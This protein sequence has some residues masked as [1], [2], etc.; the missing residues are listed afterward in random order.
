MARIQAGINQLLTTAGVFANLSPTLR[1]KAET[2]A[3]TQ[4]AE[5]KAAIQ[6]EAFDTAFSEGVQIRE[7]IEGL[8]EKLETDTN[9]I[10]KMMAQSNLRKAKEERQTNY[11]VTADVTEQR[12]ATAQEL[13]DL[14]PTKESYANLA[15]AKRDA[16]L[17]SAAAEGNR[18]IDREEAMRKMQKKGMDKVKQKYSFQDL[19][20]DV[21]KA[22]QEGY[23]NG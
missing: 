13:F 2:R 12:A 7:K 19:I 14:K 17:Y 5:R 1:A 16:K 22:E 6:Q 20:N 4:K 3:A 21:S 15:S 8:E 11:D 9:P 10:H 23:A 18:M